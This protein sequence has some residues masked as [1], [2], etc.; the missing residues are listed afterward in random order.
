M[1]LTD[2]QR[3]FYESTLAMTRQE[4][5]DLDRQ[6]EEELAKVKD[7]L[8][9]LQTAKKASRQMYDAACMRLGIPN[10]LDAEEGHS[11]EV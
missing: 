4:M 3:K 8:A 6:I 7:R 1:S 11:A 2:Q 5:E 10:D 9:E